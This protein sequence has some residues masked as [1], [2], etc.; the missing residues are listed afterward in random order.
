MQV[1]ELPSVLAYPLFSKLVVPG[2]SVISRDS[3]EAWLNKCKVLQVPL[4]LRA[5]HSV[6]CPPPLPS[7]ILR[8]HDCVRNGM[9]HRWAEPSWLVQLGWACG[10]P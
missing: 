7:H 6:V 10:L 4:P 9:K 1:L 5:G 3:L 2:S 8:D